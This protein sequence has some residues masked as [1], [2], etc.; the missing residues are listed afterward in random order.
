[1]VVLFISHVEVCPVAVPALDRIDLM[2]D[3]WEK[4]VPHD[5]MERLRREAPVCWHPVPDDSGFWAITRHADIK[6]LSRDGITYSTERGTAFHRDQEQQFIEVAR[7][8][9]LNMDPPKQTRYRR[10]VSNAFTP[11]RIAGLIETIERRAGDIADTV[12]DKGGDVEFVADIAEIVPLQ[13]ICDMLGVPERDCHL[14]FDWSNRMVGFQDPDFRTTPEDGEVAAAQIFA[15]CDE[16]VKERRKDPRDDIISVLVHG[17]VEGDRLS[18]EEIDAFFVL[19]CV[20]G[21]ETTRN[22]ISHS[23]LALIEHPDAYAELARNIDDAE[24]W[25]SATEEFLRWGSTIHSFRRTVTRDVELHGQKISAGD[26]VVLYYMSAN[27]DETVFDDPYAFDIHR[28]PNDHVAFGGGGPHF[29][30][31]ANLARAEIT[32]TIR[33]LLRRYPRAELAGPYRRMRSDF[34][35]GI[36]HM[37][38]SFAL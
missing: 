9:L 38:V 29:C 27:R 19:L 24:L 8:M 26:K 12:R 14:I 4:G 17:E 18:A 21:N 33:A 16:L 3:A 25:R 31:G 20:A 10:L 7:M 2:E 15:Y 32:A 23:M 6:A 13:M 1:L 30:L 28:N 35:N 34:I 22:L 36:K 11:R 37:P 5:Q